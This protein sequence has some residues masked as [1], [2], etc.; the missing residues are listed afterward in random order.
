MSNDEIDSLIREAMRCDTLIKENEKLIDELEEKIIEKIKTRRIV[1][2]DSFKT[3]K[4]WKF[5]FA[6]YE[7]VNWEDP[8]A[9]K[10]DNATIYGMY[11]LKKEDRAK[12]VIYV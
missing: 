12:K 8:D 4:N 9:M 6:F 3:H 11:M 10:D 1:N 7:S 2:V 5:R